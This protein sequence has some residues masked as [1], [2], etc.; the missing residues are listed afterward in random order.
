MTRPFSSTSPDVPKTQ[1]DAIQMYGPPVNAL[2]DGPGA[3]CRCPSCGQT[4]EPY[5]L[6]V[7]AL[8]EGPVCSYLMCWPCVETW[9]AAPPALAQQIQGRVLH[10]LESHYP[11]V[12]R[13]LQETVPTVNDRFWDEVKD[14]LRDQWPNVHRVLLGTRL[15]LPE[16]RRADYPYYH[17]ASLHD[18]VV[19]LTVLTR[20]QGRIPA[21]SWEATHNAF[22]VTNAWVA[23][24]MASLFVEREL[25]QALL[26]TDLPE[27]FAPEDLKWR[28]RAFRLYLPHDLFRV[29][30]NDGIVRPTCATVVR[31]SKGERI[32]FDPGIVRDIQAM[33]R[34]VGR[35][36][37]D[38]PRFLLSEEDRVVI[39]LQMRLEPPLQGASDY[40]ANCDLE[41]KTLAQLAQQKDVPPEEEPNWTQ[42]ENDFMLN[43]KR[44]VFNAILLMGAMPEEYEPEKILRP[45][46]EKGRWK[47]ELKEA[48]FLGQER[49]R[50]T[51]RPA[52]QGYEPTGRKLPGHW[53]AGH[54]KRQTYGPQSSLRKLLWI[55]PYRTLGPEETENAA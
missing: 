9:R 10:E 1:R 23:L 52:G 47:P 26:R 22:M 36:L 14:E 25:A 28:R 18:A 45:L 55:Q 44:F 11:Q 12:A 54:W 29:E 6:C 27:G 41:G 30:G 39:T 42:S 16:K 50:P 46:R 38:D 19:I 49:Y 33:Y 51:A 21:A 17:H 31:I 15:H 3:L 53:K 40:Y 24:G 35:P 20:G 43:I 5:R 32:T 4:R 34:R 2:G 8:P 37:T 48:R 13:R 7:Y